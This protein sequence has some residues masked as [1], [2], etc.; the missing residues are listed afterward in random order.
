MDE[1]AELE[2]KGLYMKTQLV[3]ELLKIPLFYDFISN[4]KYYEWDS[5]K[6][7]SDVSFKDYLDL[8]MANH[9]REFTL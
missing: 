4:I 9:F 3:I 6:E 8:F 2:I 1:Y 7:L 5:H